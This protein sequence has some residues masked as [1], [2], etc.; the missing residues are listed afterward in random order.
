MRSGMLRLMLVVAVL[1]SFPAAGFAQ[2][3]GL[4]KKKKNK[5]DT[6]KVKKLIKKIDNVVEKSEEGTAHMNAG[7]ET[8]HNILSNYKEGEFPALTKNWKTIRGELTEA[9]DDAE[10]LAKIDEAR[11]LYWK[12]LV[13]RQKAMKEM[14]K[15]PANVKTIKDKLEVP[16]VKQIKQIVKDLKAV[17][18][19]DK[20]LITEAA[21]LMK[22]ATEMSADLIKQAAKN[23]L[24]AANYKKLAGKLK[25][26]IKRLT[27]IKGQLEKQV[28]IA[29]G[30][31]EN[32][33]ALIKD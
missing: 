5:F 32:V 19:K 18:E 12:E 13:K 10:K 14:M 23:P 2:F 29:T 3:G 28:E 11:D 31:V 16:E 20:A 30:L 33:A 7:A 27:T 9:K 22:Q 26:S 8:I 1:V 25:D 4:V 17:P 6:K 24:K 15:D 21:D